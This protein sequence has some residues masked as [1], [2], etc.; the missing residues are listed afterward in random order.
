MIL[1]MKGN[2]QKTSN[3]IKQNLGK[4]DLMKSN[5]AEES[6]A[7]YVC[8]SESGG[9]ICPKGSTKQTWKKQTCSGSCAT[10]K[11]GNMLQRFCDSKKKESKCTNN[12]EYL[13]SVK[14]RKVYIL[15][16]MI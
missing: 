3:S 9:Y 14:K 15:K 13:L 6:F 4:S 16:V 8:G 11:N 12:G 7:C 1:I 5:M 2:C 10:I